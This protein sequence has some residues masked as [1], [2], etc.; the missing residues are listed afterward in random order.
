MAYYADGLF[1]GDYMGEWSYSQLL[2]GGWKKPQLAEGA[3]LFR[4]LRALGVNYFLIDRQIISPGLPNEV[5]LPRD[6]FFTDHFKPILARAGYTLFQLSEQ[7]L[8]PS[9]G[10]ELLANPGFEMLQQSMPQGWTAADHPVVDA[11][12]RESHNGLVA[13]KSEGTSNILSQKVTLSSQGMYSLSFCARTPR[14]GQMTHLWV[15]WEDDQHRVIGSDVKAVEATP[16][17]EVH[18]MFVSK[19]PSAASATIYVIGQGPGSVWFD[20]F[21]FAE[22]EYR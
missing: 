11:S 19:P 16:E 14:A 21:S 12:G 13:V 8:H 3:E 1:I 22:L 6:T 4:R 10:A 18:E 2:A 15:D 17:W 5:G 9:R 7:P 20:D